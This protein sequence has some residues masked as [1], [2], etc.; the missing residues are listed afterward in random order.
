MNKKQQNEVIK[1][2][3]N[4]RTENLK[5]YSLATQMLFDTNMEVLYKT[6]NLTSDHLKAKVYNSREKIENIKKLLD[7][8]FDKI[9]KKMYTQSAQIKIENFSKGKINEREFN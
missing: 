9:H 6:E 2:N 3:K 7:E 5:N 8:K 1:E 4:D